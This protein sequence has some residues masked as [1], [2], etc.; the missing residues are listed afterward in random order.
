MACHIRGSTNFLTQGM[1][2]LVWKLFFWYFGFLNQDGI[3]MLFPASLTF[4]FPVLC[5]GPWPWK[6]ATQVLNS[7]ALR[8]QWEWSRKGQK[9]NLHQHR[10]SGIRR[11]E[12]G[13]CHKL[14]RLLSSDMH[15]WPQSLSIRQ[16]LA[17]SCN[18]LMG[19][20]LSISVP[21][22]IKFLYNA[23]EEYL[24]IMSFLFAQATGCAWE[25][26][27]RFFQRLSVFTVTMG[28]SA[29]GSGQKWATTCACRGNTWQRWRVREHVCCSVSAA[30][31]LILILQLHDRD[32]SWKNNTRIVY[33]TCPNM[34][35]VH[36]GLLTYPQIP[37]LCYCFPLRF[38]TFLLHPY[39]DTSNHPAKTYPKVADQIC[40]AR[41]VKPVAKPFRDW[42]AH[43][44][45]WRQTLPPVQ[46]WK[47]QTQRGVLHFGHASLFEQGGGKKTSKLAKNNLPISVWKN[48]TWKI[49]L[50][51]CFSKRFLG[52]PGCT[53]SSTAPR[54]QA[55]A[56]QA[57]GEFLW[58]GDGD[59][60]ART[61]GELSLKLERENKMNT[62]YVKSWED[63]VY[64]VL[65]SI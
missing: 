30:C 1:K 48:C 5:W 15:L 37:T 33:L 29:A 57:F 59:G 22:S 44:G 2:A 18:H 6:K 55:S 64:A 32:F 62:K 45:R 26:F 50:A 23:N 52:S 28:S 25:T 47:E 61:V 39:S 10:K 3:Y 11:E 17:R 13:K 56:A 36:L 41:V 35:S 34:L 40:V 8:C 42:A 58:A 4:L 63:A 60:D 21:N 20:S 27:C 16:A 24:W 54:A 49:T 12:T 19:P 53:L 9:A 43:Q 46:H 38:Y 14:C 51:N 7:H 31:W 65:H